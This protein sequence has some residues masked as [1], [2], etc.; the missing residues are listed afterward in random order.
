MENVLILV[1]LLI[2]DLRLYEQLL[3]VYDFKQMLRLPINNWG[4]SA[5]IGGKFGLN[6]QRI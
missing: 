5:N 4:K 1:R 2:F 6:T 3:D